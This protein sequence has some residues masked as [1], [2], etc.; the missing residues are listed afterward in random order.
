MNPH[1][2]VND[3]Q[4]SKQATNKQA[5]GSAEA[6]GSAAG[7][8]LQ[9]GTQILRDEIT[10]TTRW[11]LYRHGQTGTLNLAIVQGK[12]KVTVSIANLHY[13]FDKWFDGVKPQNI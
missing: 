11:V 4:A 6:R 2:P 12:N 1:Q 9:D 3:S 5:S 7:G 13:L 8:T 10:A